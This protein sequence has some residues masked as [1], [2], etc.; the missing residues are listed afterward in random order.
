MLLAVIL[1][2]VIVFDKKDWFCL[3]RSVLSIQDYILLCFMG[4][5]VVSLCSFFT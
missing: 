3:N 5:F 2:N 4:D 1:L